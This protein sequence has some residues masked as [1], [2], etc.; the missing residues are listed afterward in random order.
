MV[1]YNFVESMKKTLLAAL[2]FVLS[3]SFLA[4]QPVA[5]QKKFYTRGFI[6]I[7]SGPFTFEQP[8][9]G[10]FNSTQ[11]QPF[12]LNNDGIMDIVC[13]ERTD[14][15]VMPFIR[16][17]Y[18][19]FRYA[20]EYESYLPDGDTYYKTADLNSDG[21]LDVFTL[22]EGSNLVIHL[23]LTKVTDTFPHFKNLGPQ[24]Y[25]NQYMPPFPIL[26]NGLALSKTD[27]PEI[28]DVD[29]DGDL[30][31]VTYDQGNA[32][33]RMYSD[34]RADFKWPKDTFEFQLMDICYGYF[35]DFNNSVNLGDCPYQ[36]KLKPRH[37]GGSSVLM[38]DNDEDGDLEMVIS[39]I[40]FKHMFF[41]ENGRKK[42]KTLYDTIV[43]YDTIF[44]RNTTRATSYYFPGGFLV[45]VD[46]DTIKDL[47]TSPTG[48]VTGFADIKETN[49]L[50]YY[51][52]FGKNNKPDFRFQKDNL[53]QDYTLDLGGKTAPAFADYDADGDMDLF[54]ANDGDFEVSGGHTDR[55]ALFKNT[56]NADTPKFEFVTTDYLGL[57]SLKLADM[58]INFGDV[59]GDK[60]QDLLIGE[61]TGKVLWFKNSGGKGKAFNLSIADTIFIAPPEIF[62]AS[63]AAPAVYNFNNDSLPDLLVGYYYGGVKLFVNSGTISKPKYTMSPGNAW[64]M[65]ANEWVFTD[66]DYTMLSYGNAVPTVLDIDHDGNDEV[67]LGTSYGRLRLYHPSGRSEFDSLS[68]DK[69]WLWQMSLTDSI[70]PDFG[71]RIVTAAHDLDGDTIPEIIIGNS[72]GGLNIA[73][74]LGSKS[75]KLAVQKLPKPEFKLYPN[76]AQSQIT[77][78]RGNIN[79]NWNIKIYS[80]LGKEMYS[81][82]MLASESD[83]TLHLPGLSDGV[84]MAEVSNG[85]T[86]T[87][88]KFVIHKP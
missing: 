71:S 19:H 35:N 30:D 69:N 80:L 59:D 64:G 76:P 40:G 60:D 77:I 78:E 54:I 83:I 52:N 66:P 26:Y 17:K 44:P 22:D 85:F 8:F 3:F 73:T 88:K 82:V 28:K 38:Y 5:S 55:I 34:V 9:I 1:Q 87:V 84:Y 2:S 81:A 86:K 57:T 49:Q 43:S 13:F 6:P 45:D 50:W 58:I 15:K 4:A 33:Y 51:R 46:G 65:R 31:I 37:S 32:V 56:G 68:A 75:G 63:N 53:F 16:L 10:G 61:R 36:D 7:K 27:I 48:G 67:L 47:V 74:A 21:K 29:G 72:R 25:R 24:G 11:F 12:D 39:N 62:G 79:G 41:L 18:D 42:F 70:E 20:P 23:N 14:N